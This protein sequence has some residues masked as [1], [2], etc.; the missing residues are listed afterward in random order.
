MKCQDCR[1]YVGTDSGSCHRFPP[2]WAV[3]SRWERDECERIVD[4]DPH[5]ALVKADD[6]CGEF[7][8]KNADDAQS[9]F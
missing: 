1:F 2:Q 7:K 9:T 5:F 4:S 3:V 8:V 6:W